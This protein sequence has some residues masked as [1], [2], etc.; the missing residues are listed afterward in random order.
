LRFE[1]LRNLEPMDFSLGAVFDILKG[2]CLQT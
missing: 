2:N 1:V